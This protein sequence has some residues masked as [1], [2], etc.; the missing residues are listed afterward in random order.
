[1]KI[2]IVG[3]IP[4]PIGGVTTYLRRLLHRDSEQ[5]ELLLDIYPGKKEP[6]A[7]ECAQKVLH[8]ASKKSLLK[9]LW[10]HRDRQKGRNVFFNFSNARALL[11]LL[12]APK[13]RGAAWTLM[14]HHGHLHCS[15]LTRQIYRL[16]LARFDEIRSLSA[17]QTSFYNSLGVSRGKIVPGSSYCE[18][19][20][21]VDSPEA[22]S[23]LEEIRRS[24]AKIVVMSGFPK[25][26]YNFDLGIDAIAAL[27]RSDIATCVFIYGPGE[28]RAALKARAETEQGLYVFDGRQERYFNTF[29]CHCDLL[30]RLTSVES[31]GI[32]VWDAH[33][34]GREIVA[35]SACERPHQSY[36]C[37]LELEEIKRAIAHQLYD[38][39]EEQL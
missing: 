37:E 8:L 6:V 9:W 3:G 2:I 29:L 11:L 7:D 33:Y 4:E 13:P 1:M 39:Q 22:L 36:V 14:L 27:K 10:T 20:D 12:L 31:F 18:P 25:P 21:H 23:Q 15:G 5:I 38:F 26:L 24:H 34:W 16:V 19:A 32:S 28:L 30:L 35:S 17:N